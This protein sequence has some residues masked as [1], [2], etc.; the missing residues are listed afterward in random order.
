MTVASVSGRISAA[1]SSNAP[2][3]AASH[4]R[5]FSSSCARVTIQ[6]SADAAPS[7]VTTWRSAGSSLR[8]AASFWTCSSF[9]ANATAAPESET[10]NA[11]SSAVD[12]G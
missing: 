4:A 12:D 6:P 11:H 7:N 9:S 3:C 8:R 10:M 2:G 5:P 1:R